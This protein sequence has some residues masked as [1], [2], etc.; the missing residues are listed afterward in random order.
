ML[1][2]RHFDLLWFFG[3]TCTTNP[4]QIEAVQFEHQC[5]FAENKPSGLQFA[6]SCSVNGRIGIRVFRTDRAP[7]VLV[8]LQPVKS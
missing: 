6:N 4:R 1:K 7:S 8:S 2:L 3:V 5:L